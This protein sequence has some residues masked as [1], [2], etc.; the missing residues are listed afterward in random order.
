MILLSG[1][2]S[3]TWSADVVKVQLYAEVLVW[4]YGVDSEGMVISQ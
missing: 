2:D 4:K 3:V 1:Y